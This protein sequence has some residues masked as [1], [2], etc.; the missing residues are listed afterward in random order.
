IEDGRRAR[1]AGADLEVGD[2]PLA[3]AVDVHEGT[4]GHRSA[5]EHVPAL[6]GVQCPDLPGDA[7]RREDEGQSSRPRDAESATML[8][9]H[10]EMSKPYALP[11]GRLGIMTQFTPPTPIPAVVLAPRLV[12][13]DAAAAIDFYVHALGA[14]EVTR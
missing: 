14:Q 7:V 1:P 4:V 8:P 9:C 6:G 5:V 13:G 11:P 2:D 12:V 3:V 10:A